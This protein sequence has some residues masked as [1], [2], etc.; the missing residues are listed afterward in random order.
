MRLPL[1]LFAAVLMS[2]SGFLYATTAK[3]ITRADISAEDRA[4]FAKEEKLALIIGISDYPD[5]SGLSRLEYADDDARDLGRQFAKM[6]YRVKV[7]VNSEATRGV[8]LNRIDELANLLDKDQ[9]TFVIAFSGHGFAKGDVNYVAPF[10][11]DINEVDRTGIKVTEILTRLKNSGAKRRVVLLD[12][13]RNDPSGG[14]K[15]VGGGQSFIKFKEAEGE[16]ILFSTKFGSKSWEYSELQHGVFTHFLIKG[17]QGAAASAGN[18]ITFRNLS[19]YVSENVKDFGFERSKYQVPFTGGEAHGD[20][21]LASGSIVI[22]QPVTLPSASVPVVPLPAPSVPVQPQTPRGPTGKLSVTTTPSGATVYV[23]DEV[24]G[25]SPLKLN[26][27]IGAIRIVARKAGYAD[28]HET[29]G[30]RID[31]EQKVALLLD[32]TS[33]TVV[34]ESNRAGGSWSLDGKAMGT[35]PGRRDDVSVGSHVI[36]IEKA[37]Y[38]N[39]EETVRVDVAGKVH[40]KGMLYAGGVLEV[41]S[42]P[43]GA[44]WH[45]DGAAMGET[46]DRAEEIAVGE[47]TLRLERNGLPNWEKNV[48]VRRGETTIVD[49]E[50]YQT[51]MLHVEANLPGATW[52]MDGKPMGAL[53]ARQEVAVGK[54]S[55]TLSLTGAPDRQGE[56]VVKGNKVNEYVETWPIGTLAFSTDIDDGKWAL[57]ELAVSLSDLDKRRLL[58]G[59]Y[60]LRVERGTAVRQ[61][62]EFTVVDGR[63]T[64]LVWMIGPEM[65]TIPA[66]CFVMGSRGGGIF[67]DGEPGRQDD[68]RQ[69]DVCIARSF[70]LGKHEVTVAEFRRFVDFTNYRTDAERDGGG[71]LGCNVYNSAQVV[72]DSSTGTSWKHPGF[73]QKDDYP[74]VCVSHSDVEKYIEWISA[75]MGKGY[76]LPSEAEWEFA[77]RAGTSTVRYWGDSAEDA[78][79][80]ANVA[81]KE[82]HWRNEFQCRD[83]Y[84]FTAPA[85][86]FVANKFGLADMLGN[87]SEWTADCWSA[88]YERAPSDGSVWKSGDCNLRIVRGGSWNSDPGWVRS[89]DRDWY[90]AVNREST[91]GFRLAQDL[92]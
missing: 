48:T 91:R 58:P 23:N 64:A 24:K 88:S 38:P 49:A 54:H 47:H 5:G 56:V 11:T 39:Y 77:A 92:D 4:K 2:V 45:L 13:C 27:P 43:V 52:A 14:G 83:G 17:L 63:A 71:V 6:G 53:P 85:G 72:F 81:N 44:R 26:L 35:V 10:E 51:G 25:V 16:S 86:S 90:R 84:K 78:C 68:E 69:H 21:L 61:E 76:R 74:V 41:A 79:R 36:R 60:R 80:Y 34:V 73:E 57:N 20:F 33:G 37:G 31:R 87:V 66:G 65:V 9:G 67:G 7:L 1:I 8:I 28:G 82:Y 12:A 19:D 59:L 55:I 29:V 32:R 40:V 89:A 22:D 18:L 42:N 62:R 50:M 3:D 70:A 46:P 15:S 30:I 75:Q